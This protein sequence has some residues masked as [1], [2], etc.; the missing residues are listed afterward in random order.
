M[1]RRLHDLGRVNVFLFPKK[2][3]KANKNSKLRNKNSNQPREKRKNNQ[4][5]INVVFE[6]RAIYLTGKCE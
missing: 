5:A 2:F 6:M 1:F 3:K 4:E